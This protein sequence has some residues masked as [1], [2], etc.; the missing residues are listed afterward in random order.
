MIVGP[1]GEERVACSVRSSASAAVYS[2]YLWHW[3]IWVF[4]LSCRSAQL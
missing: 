4:A 3:P 1:T 2:I